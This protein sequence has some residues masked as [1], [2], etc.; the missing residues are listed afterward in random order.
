MLQ[1]SGPLL[2]LIGD[3]AAAQQSTW[4]T[5]L[6]GGVDGSSAG[7]AFVYAGAVHAPYGSVDSQGFLIRL[8]G[9][10][11]FYDYRKNGADI[12]GRVTRAEALL[13]WQWWRGEVRV[14]TFAG[15]DVQSHDLS[16]PDPG[17]RV[18]GTHAGGRFHAEIAA[19]LAV[20]WRF[21]AMAAASTA[22]RAWNV[23]G[24][25]SAELSIL[26][27]G[28]PAAIRALNI[29][30]EFSASGDKSYDQ[31]RAGLQLGGLRLGPA[32]L[33]VS[34]GYVRNTRRGASDRSGAYGGISAWAKF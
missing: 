34:A 19:P 10:H 24:K 28:A 16:A 33:G 25:L 27:P 11:G 18:A 13:G 22:N 6:F 7:N 32:N 12:D 14:A 15:V 1:A 21:F 8:F 9:G 23:Y 31:W 30:P 26:T 5:L 3:P 17:N 29:G 20:G 4:S 2:F